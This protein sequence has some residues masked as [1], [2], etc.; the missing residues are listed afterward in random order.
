MGSRNPTSARTDILDIIGKSVFHAMALLESLRDETAALD[1]ED[2]DALMQAIDAKQICVDELKRLDDRRRDL[3]LQAGFDNGPFQ[4]EELAAWCDADRSIL[5]RWDH[6]MEVAAECN[7]RNLTN[8]SILR[9][10]QQHMESNLAV[11]RGDTSDTHTYHRDGKSST[12]HQHALA[13]A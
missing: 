2:S 12:R 8:G 5:N 7:A 9:M 6:L 3:C 10:R 13:R 1:A 4:M 11:L